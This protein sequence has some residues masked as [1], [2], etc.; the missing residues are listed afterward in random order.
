MKQFSLNLPIEQDYH[1]DDY[2]ISACNYEAHKAVY[3][4]E[5]WVDRR[6]LLL[7]ESGS[8]K[9]HLSNI[10]AKHYN[11][12]FVQAADELPE[13][14]LPHQAL[15]VDGINDISNEE[16][17]FHIINHAKEDGHYLL[18]TTNTYP[19]YKLR[20]LQSR[21]NA[22][23]KFLIKSPDDELLQAIMLKQFSDKQLKISADIL[24]Y[25]FVHAVR[26]FQFIQELVRTVD[27]FSLQEKR[28]ITLPLVKQALQQENLQKLLHAH[29]DGGDE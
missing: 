23:Q 18:M 6:I 29:A 21:L 3:H 24:N 9:T 7:G 13:P 8:G 4:P 22:T 20:D 1:Q 5:S 11:A 15:I 12:V 26:S 10:F 25:L 28:N 27:Q 2:I 17:L 14:N 16:W 19:A